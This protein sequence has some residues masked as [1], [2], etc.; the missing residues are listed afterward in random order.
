MRLKNWDK[1]IEYYQRKKE[2]DKRYVS[3][4]WLDLGYVYSC[5]G[6]SDKAIKCYKKGIVQD[7]IG[8]EPYRYMGDH[9]LWVL[10]DIK[11]A[12]KYYKKAY[13]YFEHYKY[14]DVCFEV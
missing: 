14:D 3:Q 2:L 11:K 12:L 1:A 4:Y 9:I 7:V 10:G 6:D 5:A 13:M 8:C